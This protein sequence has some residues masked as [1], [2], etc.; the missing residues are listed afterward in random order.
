MMSQ[1]PLQSGSLT[2]TLVLDIRK[3]KGLKPEPSPLGEYEVR[4]RSS[5]CLCL[6]C[7]YCEV[8]GWWGERDEVAW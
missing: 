4:L 5:F 2:N 1:D 3:R 8:V 7:S 6:F